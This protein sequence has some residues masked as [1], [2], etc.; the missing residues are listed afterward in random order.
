VGEGSTFHFK[1]HFEK[2]VG[3]HA[4]VNRRMP[5]PCMKALIVDDNATNRQVLTHQLNACG[6]ASEAVDSAT[7]ALERLGQDWPR[8]GFS[9][10]VTDMQMPLIDGLELSR[11]IRNDARFDPLK[12]MM[13]TSMGQPL[14]AEE[15]R[16]CRIDAC[17]SKPIK[18]TVLFERIRSLYAT[19]ES[20]A[21]VAVSP[22][23]ATPV[24]PK[25]GKI[26]LVEDNTANQRV[27]ALMLQ[28]LG[29][30]PDLVGNGLEALEA[31][32]RITY[33]LVLMDCQ[34][35]EMDGF[36][37]AR[38]IREREGSTRHTPIIALTANAMR[39]D[40]D[41]C[42]AAGM[43][44]YLSK[45]INIQDLQRIVTTWLRVS[46]V[47]VVA[48]PA[49]VI[50]S[51]VPV[52]IIVDES[53]LRDISDGDESALQELA[54]IFIDDT[55]REL[56]AL[57]TAITAKLVPEATRRAHGIAG[58]ALTYGMPSLAVPLRALEADGKVGH[59]DRAKE[60]HTAAVAQF[61][62]IQD[63]FSRRPG[64]KHAA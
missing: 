61:V 48:A 56:E 29:Y 34:M 11:K 30:A 18:Q 10:L 58:A 54:H 45:P 27:A 2:Q 40:R 9:L 51:P 20:T 3:T 55:V 36:A 39:E 63:F 21:P 43:D 60:Y 26:L 62:Q 8:S 47:P 17:L 4:A 53:R 23:P 1:V 16:R 44:D 49:P 42:I 25:H 35:P 52:N 5:F 46:E 37:A 32:T 6:I 38:E 12:I 50:A 19:E 13:V 64:W 7:A 24:V 22:K 31:L 57:E 33:D 14:S 41:K 15:Q 28:K 59:L